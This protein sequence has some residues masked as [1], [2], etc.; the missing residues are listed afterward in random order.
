[1]QGWLWVLWEEARVSIFG[2]LKTVFVTFLLSEFYVEFELLKKK[3][4]SFTA[5]HPQFS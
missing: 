3:S 1:M 5:V 2:I 4:G